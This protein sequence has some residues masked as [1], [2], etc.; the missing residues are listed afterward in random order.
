MDYTDVHRLLPGMAGVH[1]R[2]NMRQGW[3]IPRTSPSAISR[4]TELFEI[5][6]LRLQRHSLK[7]VTAYISRSRLR[8]NIQTLRRLCGDCVRLCAVVKADA[9]GH[10]ARHVVQAVNDLVFAYAVS[11]IEE[12]E[13]IH[14]FALDRPILVTGPIYPGMD[15]SLIRLAQV[16]GFHATITTIA[17]FDYL[18]A[19]LDKSR[20]PLPLPVKIDTGMGR[21]G[22]SPDTASL[23]V[24]LLRNHSLLRFAGIYT[25]FAAADEPELD[26]TPLQFRRFRDV[27]QRLHLDH[28]GGPLRHACNTLATLRLPQAHLD[29]VRCGL[30]LYGYHGFDHSLPASID[31]LPALR[32]EAP[33]IEIKTLSPG[34]TCGYGRIF[35]ADRPTTIGIV[36]LGY[37]DGLFRHLAP[38]AVMRC[39]NHL[40]PILG[41]ISMDL[42]IIDLSPLPAPHEGMRVT[43]IDDD[44]HA[45]TNAAALARH[46]RTIPYEI[47]TALGP[48]IRRELTD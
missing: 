7:T 30:G 43:V 29:M 35:R 40:L 17:A 12:A 3:Q 31:L 8:H 23:L 32:L 48:R 5:G 14:P 15:P 34:D 13:H 28:P 36:P 6:P 22:A 18:T 4:L 24:N 11:S 21:L 9:Y 44:P 26:F 16:R 20:P 19:S 2:N 10:N 25:H 1:G 45:P 38:H 27:L 47:L 42:T 33:V 41:R 46:A 37:A 39:Q